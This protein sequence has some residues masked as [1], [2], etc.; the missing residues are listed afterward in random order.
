[1][2]APE[3]SWAREQVCPLVGPRLRARAETARATATAPGSSLVRM[4][5]MRLSRAVSVRRQR[6]GRSGGN[7]RRTAWAA[8]GERWR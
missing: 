8:V 1:M 2:E 5:M 4:R 6:G 3:R 7:E